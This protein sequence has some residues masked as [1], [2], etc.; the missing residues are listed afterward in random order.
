MSAELAQAP[1]G[2]DERA[3]RAETGDEMR[4]A[5]LGLLEDLDGGR[6]VVRLPV[7]GVVVLIG[8]EVPI[9]CSAWSRRASRIAPS[10]PSIGLVTTRSAP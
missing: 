8:I 6:V 10:V 7:G 5:A 3:A 4:D 1:A 9:G 2:A